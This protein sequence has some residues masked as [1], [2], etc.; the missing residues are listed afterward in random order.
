MNIKTI[1]IILAFIALVWC[2]L[3][4]YKSECGGD[5][6]EELFDWLLGEPH[7]DLIPVAEK[8]D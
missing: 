1:E 8:K 4:I 2:A 5:L 6:T 7:P 3:G